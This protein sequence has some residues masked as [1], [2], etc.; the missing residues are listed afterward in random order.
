MRTWIAAIYEGLGPRDWGVAQKRLETGG[1]RFVFLLFPRLQSLISNLKPQASHLR[2]FTLLELAVV[3]LI[4]GLLAAVAVP[5]FTDFTGARLEAS[6]RRLAAL[7]RYLSGEAAFRSRLYRLHYDL[8][9]HTYWVTVLTASPDAAE[10][11]ADQSPLSQPVRLPSSVVFAD[12]RVADVGRVNTGQIYTHFYPHGYT[13]P[14][15]IHLRDQRSR[16]VT[17]VIP[18]ITGETLIYEGYIDAF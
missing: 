17:V 18:P 16:I 2:G 8:D 1:W 11:V 5:R 9:Q 10:F 6:A 12:I 7:I 4:I 13:D 15:I 3:L 14:T